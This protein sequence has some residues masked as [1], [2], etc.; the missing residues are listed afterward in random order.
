MGIARATVGTTLTIGVLWG[1]TSS[2]DP[3][4]TANI[5][6][7]HLRIVFIA[8]AMTRIRHIEHEPVVSGYL[9]KLITTVIPS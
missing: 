2:L 3:L 1:S 8:Q 4:V 6:G 5:A 7:L 9:L